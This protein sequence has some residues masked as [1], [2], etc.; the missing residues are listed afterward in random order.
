M[1]MIVAHKSNHAD[2]QRKIANRG[3]ECHLPDTYQNLGLR[4]SS[5]STSIYHNI[6]FD[7]LFSE[8]VYN[9]EF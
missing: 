6:R 7:Q 9:K 1:S 8:I 3:I 4:S 5:S 2:I